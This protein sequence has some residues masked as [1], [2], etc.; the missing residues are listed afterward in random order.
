MV[1]QDQEKTEGS[2]SLRVHAGAAVQAWENHKKENPEWWEVALL[3]ELAA[4]LFNLRHYIEDPKE[5]DVSWDFPFVE[6]R[7]PVPWVFPESGGPSPFGALGAVVN[8]PAT[9][10]TLTPE[11]LNRAIFELRSQDLFTTLTRGVV[12]LK[13]KTADLGTLFPRE[14]VEWIDH[15]SKTKTTPEGVEGDAEGLNVRHLLEECLQRPFTVGKIEEAATLRAIQNEEGEEDFKGF[16]EVVPLFNLPK[17]DQEEISAAF[18]EA[19]RRPDVPPLNFSGNLSTG[20]EFSGQVFA[21]FPPL[22]VNTETQKASFAWSVGLSFTKGNPKEWTSQ[23]VSEWWEGLFSFLRER[24][25]ET[26]TETPTKDARSET[27][28]NTPTASVPVGSPSPELVTYLP[29]KRVLVDSNVS[30]FLTLPALAGVKTIRSLSK[31]KGLRALEEEFKAR[32]FEDEGED[33]FK[34]TQILGE[35]RPALLERR[36][37]AKG[38][39]STNLTQYGREEFERSLVGGEAYL[40]QDEDGQEWVS[41]TYDGKRG[42]ALTV[43]FSI[44]GRGE[45]PL[46]YSDSME[47]DAKALI[48]EKKNAADGLFQ[49]SEAQRQEIEKKLRAFGSVADAMKLAKWLQS[50]VLVQR[51]TI[52]TLRLEDV[53]PLLECEK[54]ADRVERVRSALRTLRRTEY[55]IEERGRKRFNMEGSFVLEFADKAGWEDQRGQ[56]VK[57]F[58]VHVSP[59]ALGSLEAFRAATL[60]PIDAASL[61]S[62]FTIETKKLNKKDKGKKGRLHY[63]E[64]SSLAPHYVAAAQFKPLEENLRRLL[65]ENLTRNLDALAKG[66][67]SAVVFPAS[68]EDAKRPRRYGP[69]FCPLLEEGR[70]YVAALGHFNKN[71]EHGF[72]LVVP[73]GEGLLDRL[74][75]A[76]ENGKTWEE[77]DLGKFFEISRRVVENYFGGKVV[78]RK[79]GVWISLQEAA[80]LKPSEVLRTWTWF[81]FLAADFEERERKNLEEYHAGRKEKGE[82]DRTVKVERPPKSTDPTGLSVL[83]LRERFGAKRKELG[84]TVR[85]VAQI[86]GVSGVSVSKWERPKSEGGS[87]VPERFAALVLRWIETGTEPTPEELSSLPAR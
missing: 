50:E 59:W 1:N 54:D 44:M 19:A 78:A 52:V 43:S 32:L 25:G 9:K 47:A 38:E 83:S 39:E 34:E 75:F 66:R 71:A 40:R 61:V 67:E 37:N 7:L 15:E 24:R 82:T 12:H 72:R 29:E 87:G 62:P 48:Q 17:K 56:D 58:L 77:R 14:L 11:E 51:Q 55:R 35:V 80:A 26:E 64:D 18:E 68:H 28:T 42:V 36:F 74:K 5:K 2:E 8:I 65:I 79:K 30:N 22:Q 63:F 23:E 86:F 57:G 85:D 3:D 53:Y 76:P 45:S 13:T 31:V 4:G 81:F 10:G 16:E 49:G 73:N 41:R 27:S 6:L 20:R 21:A 84:L 70:E 33:V 69:D 46:G 60:P